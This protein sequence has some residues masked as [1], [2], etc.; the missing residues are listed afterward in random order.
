MFA[1]VFFGSKYRKLHTLAWFRQQQHALPKS[2]QSEPDLKFTLYNK[3]VAGFRKKLQSSKFWLL[4]VLVFAHILLTPNNSYAETRKHFNIRG[5]FLTSILGIHNIDAVF[6]PVPFFSFGVNIYYINFLV[7]SY[8]VEA[9]GYGPRINIH[10]SGDAIGDGV[11]FGTQY[12]IVPLSIE[13]RLP[14]Y[15][16]LLVTATLKTAFLG[17][18]LGYQWVWNSGWNVSFALGV[19]HVKA[20]AD[21]MASS[22]IGISQSLNFPAVGIGFPFCEFALGYAF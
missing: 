7:S 4:L 18:Y 5:N 15:N 3:E 1:F 20:T 12:T 22:E 10:L 19:L 8:N 16:N 2:M 11:Y 17:S 6:A 13:K 21:V 14:E 9:I